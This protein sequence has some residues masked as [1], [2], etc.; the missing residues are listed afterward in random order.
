[1][2]LKDRENFLDN[3]LKPALSERLIEPLYPN[4]PRHP[5]QKY[6]LTEKGLKVLH[7][8]KQAL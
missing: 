2:D 7:T 1:M 4:Q 3:Y 5:K 8:L 6:R